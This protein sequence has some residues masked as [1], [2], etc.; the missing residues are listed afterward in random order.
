MLEVKV[1]L[2]KKKDTSW[3][4]VDNER[5]ERKKKESSGNGNL[6]MI[7][8]NHLDVRY[9]SNDGDKGDVLAIGTSDPGGSWIIYINAFLQHSL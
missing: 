8:N 3:K 7:Q 9:S 4:I 2:V 1:S 6:A 5:R